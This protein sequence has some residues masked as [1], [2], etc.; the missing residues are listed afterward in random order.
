M[1]EYQFDDTQLQILSNIERMAL[2]CQERSKIVREVSFHA[3][4]LGFEFLSV[5]YRFAN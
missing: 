3:G 5:Y 2:E 4:I 1:D